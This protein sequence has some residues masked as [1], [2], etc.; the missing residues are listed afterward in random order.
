MLERQK[1]GPFHGDIC[2]F[3]KLVV[4]QSLLIQPWRWKS[5]AGPCLTSVKI[6]NQK[7]ID[8]PR[9]M[10]CSGLRILRKFASGHQV[11]GEKQCTF[12]TS[13]AIMVSL[14]HL[15]CSVCGVLEIA[16]G[17]TRKRAKRTSVPSVRKTKRCAGQ[18]ERES[19]L[20]F[21]QS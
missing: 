18:S 4:A 20:S 11:G 9:A 15:S 1:S 8:H 19:C 2:I 5:T 14:Y 17:P 7:A 3:Q 16:I 13:P 10:G 6:M 21:R 12:G